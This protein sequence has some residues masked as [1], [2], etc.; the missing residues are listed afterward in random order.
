MALVKQI[1]RDSSLKKVI[2]TNEEFMP[3]MT[4]GGGELTGY[5][6]KGTIQK[7]T[8][9]IS[10]SYG[11]E[12]YEYYFS[13][14]SLVYIHETLNGFVYDEKSDSVDHSKTEL[15]FIGHYFFK[16]DKLIDHATIG[17]NRF[18]DDTIDIGKVLVA[19]A[20]DNLSLVKRAR[21]RRN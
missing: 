7:I 21:T 20:R 15:N 14:G 16:Q 9:E 18:E 10:L 13:K 6:K 17:H 4:D 3:Q 11:I 1:D 5:F 12:T 2:L 19:E 8:R